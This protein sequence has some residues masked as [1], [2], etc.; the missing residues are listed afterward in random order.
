M[1]YFLIFVSQ[2]LVPL[3]QPV[4]VRRIQTART[5]HVDTANTQSVNW[6]MDLEE[7]VGKCSVCV[8][9]LNDRVIHLDKQI[10]HINVGHRLFNITKHIM[11]LTYFD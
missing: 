3:V 8:D 10:F 1:F 2:H 7:V 6:H 11:Y 9:M 5:L 4:Y